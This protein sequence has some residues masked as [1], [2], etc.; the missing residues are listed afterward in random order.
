GQQVRG[1]AAGELRDL[2]TAVSAVAQDVEVAD[3]LRWSGPCLGR[4]ALH[5]HDDHGAADGGDGVV[6]ADVDGLAGRHAL[7][8]DGDADLAGFEIHGGAAGDLGDGEGRAFADG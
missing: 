7:A 4:S 5:L 8:G 2:D 1:R 6:R 3:E